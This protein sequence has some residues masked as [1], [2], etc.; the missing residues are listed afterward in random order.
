MIRKI[1]RY[2]RFVLIYFIILFC[3]SLLFSNY[4]SEQI[5]AK[6]TSFYK[7]SAKALIDVNYLSDQKVDADHISKNLTVDYY[8]EFGTYEG[9]I[10]TI[11]INLD[12]H[13]LNLPMY[14]GKWFDAGPEKQVVLGKEA[15]MQ[16]RQPQHILLFG[17]KYRVSG[18]LDDLNGNSLFSGDILFN[19][20]NFQGKSYPQNLTT[21]ILFGTEESVAKGLKNLSESEV[22]QDIKLTH[23]KSAEFPEIEKGVVLSKEDKQS[24][25]EFIGL[26][27]LTLIMISGNYLSE[28]KKEISIRKWIGNSYLRVLTT[29]GLTYLISLTLGSLMALSFHSLMYFS[30]N[31]RMIQKPFLEVFFLFFIIG[32][33]IFIIQLAYVSYVYL[34]T[35]AVDFLKGAEE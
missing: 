6:Y 16:L 31:T 35:T 5:A 28:M 7:E 10:N 23:N 17:E 30:L 3:A 19:L 1:R 14:Q 9:N 26:I 12:E 13:W 24:I 4:F 27:L 18:V 22:N 2:T 11:G 34:Y 20:K 33:F 21:I 25:L 32:L 8:C 15:Y 29:F